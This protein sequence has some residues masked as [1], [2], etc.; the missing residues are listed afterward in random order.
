M[1]TGDLC[2]NF[3]THNFLHK[4]RSSLEPLCLKCFNSHHGSRILTFVGIA[5]T[6]L[7][8]DYTI[9]FRRFH[10]LL[11][12]SSNLLYHRCET[13]W[14][15]LE[16]AFQDWDACAIKLSHFLICHLFVILFVFLSRMSNK[17]LNINAVE[18][19]P[20]P[21]AAVFVPGAV[22]HSA[23]QPPTAGQCSNIS[24]PV[25]IKPEESR[26][27]DGGTKG[28]YRIYLVTWPSLKMNFS[29]FSNIFHAVVLELTKEEAISEQL[30]SV[31]SVAEPSQTVTSASDANEPV[32]NLQTTN[33]NIVECRI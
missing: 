22:T 13:K 25:D 14:L 30:A 11:A 33:G 27:D 19:K 17:G 32:Q 23:V 3:Y 7:E 15:R 4:E 18:F 9:N 26:I 28:T 8:F 24:L 6:L 1:Y 12:F 20:N 10:R 16:F 5:Y 2:P 21:T 31:C 29:V